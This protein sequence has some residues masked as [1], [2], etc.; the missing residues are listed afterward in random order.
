M[1][2]DF[3]AF[4]N[5]VSLMHLNRDLF[6]LL[7]HS[8]LQDEDSLAPGLRCYS[9]LHLASRCSGLPNQPL[10]AYEDC[11]GMLRPQRLLLPLG[12]VCCV[13]MVATKS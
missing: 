8:R 13:G 7:T 12:F 9:S 5:T 6:G 3:T 11:S 4:Y 10:Q 2:A 1:I